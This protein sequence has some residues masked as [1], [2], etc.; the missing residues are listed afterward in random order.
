MVME[1]RA[2][3]CRSKWVM[4]KLESIENMCHIH[5]KIGGKLESV[6]GT[7]PSLPADL[8]ESIMVTAKHGSS[9]IKKS[10][11]VALAEQKES[12]FLKKS[13]HAGRKLA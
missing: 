6:F 13:L 5:V 1:K 12:L 8:Q 7:F 4:A 10:H 3:Q 11:N 9:K 2:E